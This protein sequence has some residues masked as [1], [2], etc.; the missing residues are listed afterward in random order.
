M[1]LYIDNEI[2]NYWNTRDFTPSYLIISYMSRDR[3]QELLNL[4][5]LD[6]KD[7]IPWGETY[8][9]YMPNREVYHIR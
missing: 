2:T 7:I 4:Q 1:T 6:K 3:F 8:S 9:I 5:K